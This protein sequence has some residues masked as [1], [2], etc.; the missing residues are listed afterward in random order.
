MKLIS[1]LQRKQRGTQIAEFALVLPLL[2]FLALLVTEGS[3]LV[4]M[5]QALNNI[6][7]EGARLAA[8]PENQP[9]SDRS[10][11]MVAAMKAYAANNSVVFPTLTETSANNTTY[12]YVWSGTAT[13]S[14]TWACSNLSITI[15]Q[16]RNVVTGAGFTFEASQVTVACG[17]ALQYLPKLPFFT[18]SGVINLRG[19]AQF[20]NMYGT[21]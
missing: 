6:A 12:V 2:A 15:E 17:Y 18:V 20:R 8:Q 13:G 10:A 9:T 16:G 14:P 19:A 4:R 1:P 7:R 21:P 5:H 3:G 11:D